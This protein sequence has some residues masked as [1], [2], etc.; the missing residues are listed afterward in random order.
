MYDENACGCGHVHDHEPP[1]EHEHGR[2]KDGHGLGLRPDGDDVITMVDEDGVEHD[3]EI[4]DVLEDEGSYYMALIPVFD[5]AEELL[6]DTGD[7][8]VLKVVAEGAQEYLE[9]IDDEAE[10]NRISGMFM[11]RLSEEYDF[12]E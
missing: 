9:T 2:E 3:F 8:I 12:E 6:D 1:V 10:F 5:T 7:L 4:A 11:E